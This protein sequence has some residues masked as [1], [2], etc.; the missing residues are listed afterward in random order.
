MYS[1]LIVED[2]YYVRSS[3]IHRIE[4]DKLN[5]CVAGEADNGVKAL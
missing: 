3:L 2:E 1:V 4:W 5:L